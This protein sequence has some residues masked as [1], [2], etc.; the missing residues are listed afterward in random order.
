M[1]G[2]IGILIAFGAALVAAILFFK[3][4]ISPQSS[5]SAGIDYAMIFYHLHTAGIVIASIYLMYALLTHQFQY[6][7]VYAHSNLDLPLKYLVSAFWAGQEGTFLLWA[8]MAALAGYLLMK[9]E[10]E[11]LP[12]VMPFILLGQLFL[13]LFLFL[14]TPFY[15]LGQVPADGMGM[16]PLLM[17]P[18][19]VIHP[20]IVFIG[21]ALLTI[22]FAYAAAALWKKDW[23]AGFLRAL[24]W[25]GAG[26]L[27]LGAGIFIGAAWAYRVL[28]WGGYWGWDPVENA[29]LVPWLTATALVH[30]LVGQKQKGRFVKSNLLL[31]IITFVLII[32]AAF[33][34]RGGVMADYSVH[35]FAETALTYVL[36][37]FV[38]VYLVLGLGLYVARFKSLPVQGSSEGIFSR[39]GSFAITLVVLCLSA[40]LVLLGT[41]SPILT[42]LFGSPASVDEQF[43][44]QTNSPLFFL[45]FV[46]LVVCP[47]LGWKN[48]DFKVI[49]TRL[50]KI[51]IIFPIALIVAY[52]AGITSFLNLIF[53]GIMVLALAVNVVWLIRTM[54]AGLKFSGAYLAHV[55][56]ALLFIGVLASTAYTQSQLLNLKKGEPVEA[57]GLEFTYLGLTVEGENNYPVVQIEDGSRVTI[58]RPNIYIAGE[59]V[60]RSPAIQRN[61][62]RDLYISPMELQ[63]AG[64]G[65]TF[66]LAKD[67]QYQVEDYLIIFRDF[68]FV[69][70]SETNVFEVG[71]LLE[72]DDGDGFREYIPTIVQNPVE[73]TSNPITLPGG[74][75]IIMEE[76]DA[77]NGMVQLSF[78]GGESPIEEEIFIAEVKIKPLISIL[79]VGAVLLVA[80]TAISVW[81]RFTT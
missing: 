47:L 81:R 20:P 39:Q 34:T 11:L 22:P 7:Y 48:E 5:R 61:I 37:I 69:S 79:A 59:Q 21:Y 38:L 23:S 64:G 25:A 43:Y 55:G 56:L 42:G 1:I 57:L 24:P 27:F 68:T 6:F 17:D 29:S 18:W 45:L 9:K 77:D 26:W 4:A 28:G 58:A 16:N 10:K 54:K 78:E 14:E 72:V 74:E 40:L 30:G 60:M 35:A 36:G 63:I 73:R 46:V 50:K 76:V 32:V 19:M 53:I 71:A 51:L 75:R 65:E 49:F 12:A 31:A 52:L 70:H 3:K 2:N 8:L 44:F 62:F 13:M 80:G 15:H 33:L 67:E 41:L 66:V